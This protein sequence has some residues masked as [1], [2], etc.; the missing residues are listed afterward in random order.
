MG[1]DPGYDPYVE[2]GGTASMRRSGRALAA[3]RTAV[4]GL[5]AL[6]VLLIR[7]ELSSG[8]LLRPALLAL[9][10]ICASALLA[11]VTL[12]RPPARRAARLIDLLCVTLDTLALVTIARITVDL[13]PTASIAWAFV[14]W[15]PFEIAQRA[16]A[17]TAMV[18]TF[19]VAALVYL[20]NANSPGALHPTMASWTVTG[21][22]MLL[23]VVA[24]ASTVFAMLG[25]H[26]R[27]MLVRREL[28]E[29]HE[30][31]QQ[32]RAADELKNTFLAATTHEL[33]TPLTSILGF[34]LTML[35]RPDLPSAQR[36]RMLRTVVTEAEQLEDILTNLL[37]MDRLA[38]G[39]STLA[40]AQVDPAQVVRDAVGHVHRRTGRPI[41]L[42]LE[43]DVTM[44]LDRPKVERIV[45]NLVSNAVK[46]TPRDATI[47]VEMFR[48]RRGITV[49]VDDDGPGVRADV[50]EHIFEPFNRGVQRGGGGTGIGLSIVE[51]FARMHGG[52]ATVHDRPGGGARFEVYLPSL[53]EVGSSVTRSTSGRSGE[54]A[55]VPG[56]T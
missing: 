7:D 35:D 39:K 34:S 23:V 13:D 36:E 45:E 8:G 29:A 25:Q 54:P 50:R 21:V 16:R 2:I 22:P 56:R 1:P 47:R 11:D 27:G 32:L 18:G 38:R 28:H 44:H 10:G 6:H 4:A 31:S 48:D 52:R 14:L 42:E 30:R 40:S 46:Y 17:T 5:V 33:R 53:G 55:F 15:V 12:R 19:A 37:D 49:R 41:R 26:R 43:C 20:A 24:G 3:L 51:R 9:V